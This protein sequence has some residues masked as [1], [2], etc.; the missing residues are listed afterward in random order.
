[1]ILRGNVSKD[2]KLRGWFVGHFVEQDDP[3][4]D[5]NVEVSWSRLKENETRHAWSDVSNA[6]TLTILVS[7]CM[8]EI[9]RTHVTTLSEPGDYVLY[10]G[11]AHTWRACKN[12]VV[13]TVRWP[14]GS[15]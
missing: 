13:I 1:M 5:V 2:A 7:G 10:Q 6:K 15:G 14:S 11:E 3:R 9:F 4:H 12:S 8:E